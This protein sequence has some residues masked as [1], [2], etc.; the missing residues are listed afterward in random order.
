M[1]VF[2][3]YTFCEEKLETRAQIETQYWNSLNIEKFVGV[4][5]L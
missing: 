4:D 3:H 2:E 5:I 1:N